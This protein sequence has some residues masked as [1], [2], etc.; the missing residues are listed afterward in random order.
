V[1]IFVSADPS[2]MA[3]NRIAFRLRDAVRRRDSASLALSGGSTAPPMIAALLADVVPWDRVEI[4]QVD[5]RVAPEG[6]EARNANQLD[7]LSERCAVH[8]MPVT[9]ADLRAGARRYGTG[10]PSRFDVVHLGIGDDGH[11]ASWPPGQP[12]T[13]RSE[14]LVELVDDFHGRPRMTLTKSVVDDARTRVVLARGASKRPVIERWLLGDD[15]L[16]ISWV[17]R[18]ATSIYLDDAAAPDAPLQ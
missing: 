6:D 11:T 9:A 7:A 15:E 3:A 17:R 4:W 16:P 10:L 18:T 14:R 12:E 2:A 8:L 13:A 5:E 1:D